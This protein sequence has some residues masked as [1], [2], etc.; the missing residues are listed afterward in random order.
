MGGD[1]ELAKIDSAISPFFPV[2]R[3]PTLRAATFY[4]VFGMRFIYSIIM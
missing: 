2:S 4:E 1:F 3:A